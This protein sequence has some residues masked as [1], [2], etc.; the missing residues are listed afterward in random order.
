MHEIYSAMNHT[1]FLGVSVCGFHPL[2]T[3]RTAP[4]IGLD[5]LT[6]TRAKPCYFLAPFISFLKSFPFFFSFATPSIIPT[7]HSLYI[8]STSPHTPPSDNLTHYY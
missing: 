8:I 6:S 5:T 7:F 3:T 2:T 4:L 1:N